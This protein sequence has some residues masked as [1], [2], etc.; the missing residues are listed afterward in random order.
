[1]TPKAV[2][3]KVL[4]VSDDEDFSVCGLALYQNPTTKWSEVT[5]KNCLRKRTKRGKP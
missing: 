3:H 5:C 2:V 4:F 1:M